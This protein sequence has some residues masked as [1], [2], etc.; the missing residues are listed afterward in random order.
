MGGAL[1]ALQFGSKARN[2]DGAS[3]GRGSPG[4]QRAAAAAA[5]APHT[6]TG[7]TPLRSSPAHPHAAPQT[8]GLLLAPGREGYG[9]LLCL[10]CLSPDG[11]RAVRAGS[12]APRRTY[13]ATTQPVRTRLSVSR[14]LVGSSGRVGKAKRCQLRGE[15]RSSSFTDSSL[16][17]LMRS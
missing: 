2:G 6:R 11:G 8:C 16:V 12:P 14:R 5:G 9:V 10:L 3:Q 4:A 1:K 13:F 17:N 15:D 7:E